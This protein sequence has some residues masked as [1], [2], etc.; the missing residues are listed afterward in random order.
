MLRSP[1][2]DDNTISLRQYIFSTTMGHRIPF[3]STVGFRD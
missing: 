3:G 2:S 1:K